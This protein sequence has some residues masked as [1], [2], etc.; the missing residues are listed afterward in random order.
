MG[1]QKIY[2]VGGVEVDLGDPKFAPA[3]VVVL[4]QK[5]YEL[6]HILPDLV[7][8]KEP[9]PYGNYEYQFF[10]PGRTYDFTYPCGH[11][12]HM[13]E[14]N[15]YRPQCEVCGKAMEKEA[16][17]PKTMWRRREIKKPKPAIVQM[18]TGSGTKEVK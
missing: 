11:Q 16:A 14:N 13:T 17:A 18:L 15:W 1:R 5:L 6:G 9:E 7:K 12:Y 10:N 2:M 3:E 4:N 8:V